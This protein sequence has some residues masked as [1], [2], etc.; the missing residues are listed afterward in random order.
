MDAFIF[1]TLK[2][3]FCLSAGYLVYYL[4]F[5]RETFHRFKR[6]TILGIITASLVV[7]LIKL[8]TDPIRISSP[9]QKLEAEFTRPAP[10]VTAGQKLPQ[11]NQ[12]QDKSATPDIPALVYLLGA[13]VQLIVILYSVARTL[14]LI[15]KSR[16][17]KYQ[18][19]RIALLPTGAVP[20]C[21]GR[22][23]VLSEKDFMDHGKAV[24][25]HEQTHLNELHSLDLLIS[26]LYLVMTWYNPVSWL[27]R[28]E[29]KQNHEFEADRHVLSQG[30]DESD[31]QLLLLRRAAGEPRYHLANQ[32]NQS[33]IKTRIAMMTKEKSNPAGILK[34][35]F[36]I[37]LIALMVQVFAQKEIKPAGTSSKGLSQER[38]LELTPGQLNL[39]GFESNATG[40][41]YKNIRFGRSDKGILCLYFTDDSYS[42]SIFLKPGEQITGN[43]D[44]NRILKKQPLTNFDFYPVV[45]AGRNGFRTQDMI[46]AEKDPE[47]KLLP[48]QVNMASVL[49][50]KRSDTLIF[51]FKPTKSLEQALSPVA[52]INDYLQPCPP[53]PEENSKKVSAPSHRKHAK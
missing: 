44:H 24:I 11:L 35:L 50:G 2:S 38:Y 17:I 3:S 27:I 30:V 52:K 41:F 26:E 40:L 19:C 43:S 39:L 15:R 16:K 7:P 46:A 4:L 9:V 51:W 20:F 12:Q 25:L 42:G 32:F 10:V 18:G 5:R 36:F 14:L 33:N 6:F 22:Q 48:V 45:V 49:P 31:Y 28:H 29:I 37:P 13:S 21:F 47:M 1:F 34:I 8:Q 23:I 53:E